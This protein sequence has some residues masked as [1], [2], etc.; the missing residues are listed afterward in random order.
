MEARFAVRE[1][2]EKKGLRSLVLGQ[3]KRTAR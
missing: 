2:L 1:K 3:R